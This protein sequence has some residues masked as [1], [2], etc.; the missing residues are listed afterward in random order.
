MNN[1]LAFALGS[2]ITC[3]LMLV[4]VWVD[5]IKRQKIIAAVTDTFIPLR[6]LLVQSESH[7]FLIRQ[8]QIEDLSSLTEQD[9]L[10]DRLEQKHERIQQ[11]EHYF[12]TVEEAHRAVER[13]KELVHQDEN[14]LLWPLD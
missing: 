10:I 1:F 6:N 8:K 13:L 11:D 3:F 9:G 7:L 14:H 5:S 2:I 12:T 4:P